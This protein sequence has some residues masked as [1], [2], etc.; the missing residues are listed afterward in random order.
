MNPN[1]ENP[2][3]LGLSR[4][5]DQSPG[6]GEKLRESVYI[7]ISRLI[8]HTSPGAELLTWVR[9]GC[10]L[11][12]ISLA[13]LAAYHEKT[14]NGIRHIIMSGSDQEVVNSIRQIAAPMQ[15]D[16]HMARNDKPLQRI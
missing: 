6:Y 10:L 8:H 15:Q 3:Q 14:I 5:L 13:Q 1:Q 7:N 16:T 4:L 12:N 11:Q 2:P 9:A